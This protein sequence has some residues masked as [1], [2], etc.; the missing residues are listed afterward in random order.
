MGRNEAVDT[1]YLIDFG[2]S[3]YFKDSRGRHIPMKDKKSFIGTT[4]YASISAHL[5]NELS[6]KDDLESLGYVLIFLL[7]G[8]L[9]WQNLNVSDKEKTKKVGEMKAKITPEELCKDLP[10][11]LT[12]YMTYVKSL[13]FVEDPDYN[14]LRGLLK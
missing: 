12:N 1:C 2:I 4:R 8:A 3:K 7:K 5:G 11:E 10:I 9:P 14:Y 13:M 6:R